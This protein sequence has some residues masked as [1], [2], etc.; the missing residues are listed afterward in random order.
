MITMNL[1]HTIKTYDS[2]TFCA[3]ANDLTDDETKKLAH[4][5]IEWFINNRLD[6][7][8]LAEFLEDIRFVKEK[9]AETK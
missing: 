9:E 1:I 3:A 4:K 6:G 2:D 8:L 7:V 5:C